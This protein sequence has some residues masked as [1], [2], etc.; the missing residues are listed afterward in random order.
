MS[1]FK[2]GDTVKFNSY[3]NDD[4]DID[5]T[6]TYIISCVNELNRFLLKQD[7]NKYS[8]YSASRFELVEPLD[9]EVPNILVSQI[10]TQMDKDAVNISKEDYEVA[11]DTAKVKYQ[12]KPF[13]GHKEEPTPENSWDNF[14]PKKPN[15]FLEVTGSAIDEKKEDVVNNPSHYKT[16]KFEV[17]E[18][19]EAL[20][21]DYTLGNAVKYISRAGKKDPKKE[22]ED[23][24]K[25][26]WYINRRIKNLKEK[27]NV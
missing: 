24:S 19:I 26:V 23:L 14:K 6:K 4:I 9:K 15:P 18:I 22:V 17:I 7:P 8:W 20:K 5:I 16:G 10:L 25:A 3:G 13:L 12:D 11:A 1:K 21:L 27:S 2:V